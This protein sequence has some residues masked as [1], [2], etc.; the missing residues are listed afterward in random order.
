MHGNEQTNVFCEFLVGLGGPKVG[1]PAGQTLWPAHFDRQ[2]FGP[3]SWATGPILGSTA[4]YM[5]M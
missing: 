2:N 1:S 4:V 5:T 3:S